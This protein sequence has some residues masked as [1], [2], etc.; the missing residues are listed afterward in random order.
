MHKSNRR[1]HI[2][3]TFKA[4]LRAKIAIFAGILALSLLAFIAACSMEIDERPSSGGA[5]NS[6]IKSVDALMVRSAVSDMIFMG[7]SVLYSPKNA[8]ANQLAKGVIVAVRLNDLEVTDLGSGNYAYSNSVERYQLGYIVI[9]SI[10]DESVSFSYHAFDNGGTNEKARP[11]GDFTVPL[12]GTADLNGDG[13]ADITYTKPLPGRKGYKTDKWLTFICDVNQIAAS[14]FS[15]IPM[16][17]ARSVYPNGLFGINTNGQYIVQKYDIGTTNRA[18]ISA[19]SYGDYVLDTETNTVSVYVGEERN[20]RS[21]RALEDNVLETMDGLSRKD[22]PETFEFKPHEFA[23]TES[24][25]NI[26]DL[27]RALPK[28]VVTEAFDDR[29]VT[30]NVAYLN[31]LIR[32]GGF[33][34]AILDANPDSQATAEI[35]AQLAKASISGELEQVLFNRH[36]LALLYP[37]L[38]PDVSLTSKTLSIIFPFLFKQ[39]GNE[40]KQQEVDALVKAQQEKYGAQR[41]SNGKGTFDENLAPLHN[42]D[43]ERQREFTVVLEEWE[44]SAEG[45]LYRDQLP[46]AERRKLVQDFAD[47]MKKGSDA[48]YELLDSE[49]KKAHK[50]ASETVG[51]EMKETTEQMVKEQKSKYKSFCDE[52]Q[53]ALNKFNELGFK[54]DVLDILIKLVDVQILKDLVRGS[55]STGKIGVGGTI[56]FAKMQP[57]IKV[58]FGVYAGFELKDTLSLSLKTV[59]LFKDSSKFDPDG[60]WSPEETRKAFE[61]AYPD[62]TY[63]EE[64]M[65]S[66]MEMMNDK[67][68]KE[69]YNLDRWYFNWNQP[70]RKTQ[71]K[72]YK[73]SS[74]AKYKHM[75]FTPAPPLPL[76]LTLDLKFD[77]LVSVQVVAEF[78]GIAV[79][80]YSMHFFEASA[81]INWGFRDYFWGFIPD[82]TSFYFKS[83]ADAKSWHMNGFFA[84]CYGEKFTVSRAYPLDYWNDDGVKEGTE[85]E[86][87][88]TA[89]GGAR[90]VVCPVFEVRPGI[91]LGVGATGGSAT[92]TVGVSAT[93]YTPV[94]LYVGF[95]VTNN[96]HPIFILQ[97]DADAG[98]SVG[99]NLKFTLDL[100]IIG[101]R[102]WQWDIPKLQFTLQAQLLR[103]RMENLT[104]RNFEGPT[105]PEFF[106][107]KA[108]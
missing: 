52:R 62:G 29:D 6:P 107:G 59:S 24:S 64:Y 40:V 98:L 94:A 74:D 9:S 78:Q 91:G 2:R 97:T 108:E 39:W 66:Y 75:T 71:N 69:E 31:R 55:N 73:P 18:A 30:N 5:A 48:F 44:N 82:P 88:W 33:L 11:A 83:Y 80:G 47:A 99:G 23:G 7:G 26:Y 92:A 85:V 105:V 16:Q 77:I 50:K 56:S 104:I 84:G 81:G 14:M 65:K 28:S 32:T 106:W 13:K 8:N 3:T 46:E 68:V 61:K 4:N 10:S 70:G 103:F 100:P 51:K 37:A 67:N 1:K 53:T 89:G 96:L 43:I 25:K 86:Y 19:I 79:A 15:I 17:Y 54:V 57:Y 22:T 38:C 21:A 27:L 60:K 72:M 42:A 41:V 90:F 34:S 35:R 58:Q 12:G 63:D 49:K 102:D 36:S 95:S 101:P 93:L 76:E 87:D 45:K 20:G